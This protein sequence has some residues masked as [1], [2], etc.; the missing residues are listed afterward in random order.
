MNI[1]Q[2]ELKPP[3]PK[4]T[5]RY[6]EMRKQAMEFAR[7]NPNAW[8]LFCQFTFEKINQGFKHYS[9]KGVFERIRWETDQA[10]SDGTT[11]K[12]GNNYTPFFARAF[13]KKYPQYDGFFRVREQKS[14]NDP[15]T[16]MP[17]LGYNDFMDGEK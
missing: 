7:K 14:K 1:V 3:P 17:E 8:M 15:A 13:M 5:T 6:E 10:E 9:A 12:M 2:L 16:G 11:F 4:V